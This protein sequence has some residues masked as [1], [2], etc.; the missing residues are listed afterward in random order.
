MENRETKPCDRLILENLHPGRIL[1][2]D[3]TMMDLEVVVNKNDFGTGTL[4]ERIRAFENGEF[5]DLV[6]EENRLTTLWKT[7]EIQ[8]YIADFQVKDVDNDGEVELV[9]AVVAPYEGVSGALST[10]SF[11]NVYFLKLF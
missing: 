1:L 5:H 6:W 2:R 9:T 4:F 8:G 10:K 7:T 11:S 3:P